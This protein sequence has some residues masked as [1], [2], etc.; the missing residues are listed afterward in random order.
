MTWKRSLAFNND[1]GKTLY[2]KK[3]IY[4]QKKIK[5]SLMMMISILTPTV[6]V[7]PCPYN[8]PWNGNQKIRAIFQLLTRSAFRNFLTDFN[9]HWLHSEL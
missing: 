7:G 1:D 2:K 4:L 9:M 8:V 3:Q 5:T 6:F